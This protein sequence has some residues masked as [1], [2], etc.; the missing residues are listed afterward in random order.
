MNKLRK[1]DLCNVCF[2]SLSWVCI[3]YTVTDILKVLFS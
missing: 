3:G 2:W 1:Q